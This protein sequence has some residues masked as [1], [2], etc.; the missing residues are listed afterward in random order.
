MMREVGT[1]LSPLLLSCSVA[2]CKAPAQARVQIAQFGINLIAGVGDQHKPSSSAST[3][4][5]RL[6]LLLAE[7]QNAKLLAQG[8]K[9]AGNGDGDK[10]Q[11][12]LQ[13]AQLEEACACSGILTTLLHTSPVHGQLYAALAALPHA[14]S[15]DGNDAA[16][17]LITVLQVED[18]ALLIRGHLTTSEHPCGQNVR[19]LLDARLGQA[20]LPHY[21]CTCGCSTYDNPED[22]WAPYPCVKAL[23]TVS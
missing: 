5:L 3:S 14:R 4:V 7:L 12:P 17:A 16:A 10:N 20:A 18:C 15:A 2:V 22:V 13:L 9:H 11:A 6:R 19:V 1:R 8:N 21:S 23:L